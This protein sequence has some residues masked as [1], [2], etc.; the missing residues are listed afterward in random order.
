M[1]SLHSREFLTA[2]SRIPGKTLAD[3]SREGFSS[4]LAIVKCRLHPADV[5]VSFL[6]AE[7]HWHPIGAIPSAPPE[8]ARFED[9][10]STG[11]PGLTSGEAILPLSTDGSVPGVLVLMGVSPSHWDREDGELLFHA[12][13]C[14]ADCLRDKLYRY[15]VSHHRK[16]GGDPDIEHYRNFYENAIEGFY[17]TTLLGNY[18]RANLSLAR[19]YG[20]ESVDELIYHSNFTAR[21]LYV[22][23]GRREA[24]VEAVSRTDFLTGFESRVHRRD[25]SIIWIS[26]SARVIRDESGRILFFEGTVTD[27]TKQKE[28][29]LALLASRNELEGR[30]ASRTRQLR[31]EM[32]RFDRLIG[33]VPGM[34]YQFEVSEEG[35]TRLTYVS[36]GVRDLYG[37]SPIE[38]LAD[39]SSLSDLIHPDDALSYRTSIKQAMSGLTPWHWLGRVQAPNGN[40]KW[41]HGKSRP[42]R[43]ESGQVIRSESGAIVWDGIVV[44]VTE[45]QEMKLELQR[46]LQQSSTILDISPDGILTIDDHGWI[47]GV[48]PA[49]ENMLGSFEKG[50]LGRQLGEL[51]TDPHG[52]Y[53]DREGASPFEKMATS[54]LLGRR[55][56]LTGRRADGSPFPV[57]MTLSPI[58]AGESS[59]YTVNVRDISSRKRFEKRLRDSRDEAQ[60]ANLAKSEFLSRMSHELRTPLNAILGFSQLLV[61]A[62]NDPVQAEKLLFIQ[63]AGKHL[64]D[65]I[66]EVLDLARIEA[67]KLCCSIEEVSMRTVIEEIGAYARP[68]ALENRIQLD[69][70]PVVPGDFVVF[71]DQQRLKQILLNLVANAI[72]Y[73]RPDGLVK[74]SCEPVGSGFLEISIADTG[75]GMSEPQL[76]DLF[77]PFD[78]LGADD[79]KSVGTGIGLALSQSLA[80]LMGSHIHVST[81]LGKGSCFSLR[82]RRT[83]KSVPLSEEA[84]RGAGPADLPE[85]PATPALKKLLYIE[86]NPLNLRLIRE[87]VKESPQWELHAA[88]TGAEGIKRALELRPGMIFLDVHLPD[89][90]GD[91]VLQRLR[92]EPSLDDTFIA[93]LTADAMGDGAT[94]F[95]QLGADHFLTKPIDIPA[96]LDLL[97]EVATREAGLPG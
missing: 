82:L 26:E 6:D 53:I 10:L 66:N 55:S 43:D 46:S 5:F 89:F 7:G 73:N 65:L 50:I 96:I 17:Q 79:S 52:A 64:L 47:L 61:R 44:D 22:E 77:T 60:R 27:I 80:E 34:V 42:A 58:E 94:V 30:V 49:A 83:G 86:D 76:K 18:L 88:E 62:E 69:L 97:E 54:P 59:I 36:G 11:R 23:E 90:N 28:A 51:F 13:E 75:P 81:E 2:L 84:W 15:E 39:R 71:A 19:M 70:G 32:S 78:R 93:M 63:R 16:S 45:L 38:A 40:S 91:K 12:I 25:G 35:R 57:E 74:V 87:V 48:N 4:I 56:E 1:H 31:E 8:T 29:E 37:L 67:G 14:F 85:R 72:K 92:Q 24:F 95:R 3:L 9:V 33:N 21:H 20:Y 41:I 68:L